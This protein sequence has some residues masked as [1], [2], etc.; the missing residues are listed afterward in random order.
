MSNYK[1][2][3]NTDPTDKELKSQERFETQ[4]TIAKK[5][6]EDAKWIQELSTK[7]QFSVDWYHTVGLEILMQCMGKK[8]VI[9]GFKG[10]EQVVRL[11][12]EKPAIEVLTMMAKMDGVLVESIKGKI[13]HDIPGA[14]E[15]KHTHELLPDGDR[16]DQVFGI[17]ESCGVFPKTTKK[18]TRDDVEVISA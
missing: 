17:L 6:N 12:K 9:T 8:E 10:Q 1:R 11:F 13:Q 3:T 7:E 18:L 14:I 5:L 2:G 15:H 4:A 16:T